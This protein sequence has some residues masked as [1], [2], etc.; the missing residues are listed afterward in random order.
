[1]RSHTLF[2][3]MNLHSILCCLGVFSGLCT[4]CCYPLPLWAGVGLGMFLNEG[5]D[6]SQDGLS[7]CEV[8]EGREQ[9][10]RYHLQLGA[11][12]QFAFCWANNKP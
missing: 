10:G 9:A 1:M 12:A 8:L 11:R 6:C 7:I 3:C 2:A 4:T 5:L